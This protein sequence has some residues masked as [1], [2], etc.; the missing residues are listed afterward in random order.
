MINTLA[1][2]AQPP[3]NIK[4]SGAQ[5]WFT[6]FQLLP[7]TILAGIGVRHVMR[8]EGPVLLLC[9][10]GGLIACLWEPIVDVLGM[11]Y[12]PGKGQ[13]NAFTVFDRPIPWLIP[14]VYSW[15]VGGMGYLAYRLFERGT[16]RRTVF[17]LWAL[18][19]AVNIV[20]ESPGIIA[21]VYTYYGKQPL[22]IWGFPLWWGFVNPVMP[23]IAGALIYKLRPHLRS[24]WA[25]LG[26]IP[27]IPMADGLANAAAGW[28]VFT[29]LNSSLGY[30]GT[31]AA[32]FAT[33]ALSLYVV[34]WVSLAVARPAEHA[35]AARTKASSGRARVNEQALAGT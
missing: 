24:S 28:P 17:R 5:G 30:A 6:I 2:V 7:L 9:L 25:L 3:I 11:C 35:Q 34:W 23:L 33:L 15:Y 26:I 16:D 31:Y 13:W 10:V 19:F 12:L 27:L 21:D 8:G 4:M 32:A 14:A 22:N 29:A 18:L 1:T 20:L